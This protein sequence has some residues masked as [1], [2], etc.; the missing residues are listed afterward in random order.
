MLSKMKSSTA[1]EIFDFPKYLICIE[2]PSAS[3][4][5]QDKKGLLFRADLIEF[6]PKL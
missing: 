6:T 5:A 2:S 4:A 3:F 1:N